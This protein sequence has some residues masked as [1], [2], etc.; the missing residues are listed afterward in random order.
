MIDRIEMSRVPAVAFL[1]RIAFLT[2]GGG[3][4][5]S[6]T[7]NPGRTAQVRGSRPT[8]GCFP[9]R[10]MRGAMPYYT[11]PQ[12]GVLARREDAGDSHLSG[13]LPKRRGLGP[14]C[15]SAWDVA[16]GKAGHELQKPMKVV[17]ASKEADAA[18]DVEGKLVRGNKVDGRPG[19]SRRTAAAGIRSRE[20]PA[21]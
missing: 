16:I 20:S 2:F 15:P 3:C 8:G 10:H 21:R 4:V 11:P 1:L 12:A 17:E 19:P 6:G 5:H 18:D 13:G 9:G 7:S 14:L